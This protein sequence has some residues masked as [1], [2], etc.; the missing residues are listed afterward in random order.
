[1]SG[2]VALAS[3]INCSQARRV[4]DA[5]TS[6]VHDDGGGGAVVAAGRRATEIL[7]QAKRAFGLRDE[8]NTGRAHS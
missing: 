3:S 2:A 8:A 7:F 5:A 4:R 6:A 1:V